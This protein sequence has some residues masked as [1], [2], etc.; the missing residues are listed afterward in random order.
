MADIDVR[1]LKRRIDVLE[2]RIRPLEDQIKPYMRKAKRA[3]LVKEIM[4]LHQ[5]QLA[6]IRVMG[7]LVAEERSRGLH[8]NHR[9]VR[10]L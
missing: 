10:P 3:V 5:D 7:K 4:A 8:P 9:A 6:C 1:L 2:G